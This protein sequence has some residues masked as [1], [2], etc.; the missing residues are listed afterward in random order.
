MCLQIFASRDSGAS[1]QPI[2]SVLGDGVSAMV[3]G[4]PMERVWLT[5]LIVISCILCRQ[6]NAAE[7]CVIPPPV[8]QVEGV[9][10]YTDKHASTVDVEKQAADA[11]SYRPIQMFVYRLEKMLDDDVTKPGSMDCVIHNLDYWAMSHAMM[12]HPSNFSGIRQRAR[13]TIALNVIALKL[14]AAGFK[15]NDS[16]RLWLHGLSM[17]AIRDFEARQPRGNLYIWSGVDAASDALLS[18]DPTSRQYATT[19]WKQGIAKINS[20]GTVD[21]ELDRASRSLLYHQ[22]YLSGLLML[23][24][25]RIALGNVISA[26]DEAALELLATRVEEGLCDTSSMSSLLGGA[27]QE[28]PPPYQFAVPTA[29]GQGFFHSAWY[30]CANIPPSL[31]D[32]GAG[33]DMAKLSEILKSLG[34]R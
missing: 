11:A 31:I 27:E 6:G 29:F 19:V 16:I 23:R 7:V 30:R 14:M 34:S 32:S 25:Y 3:V 9:D 24:S 4:R 12:R 22:Y 20:N 33:G 17:E 5:A 8:S 2:G 13:F 15:L 21:T 10:F 1:S 28:I 26:A 18:N